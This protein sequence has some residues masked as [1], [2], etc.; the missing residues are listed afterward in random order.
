MPNLLEHTGQRV[1]IE[2]ISSEPG[3]FPH[4]V[5]WVAGVLAGVGDVTGTI[6]GFRLT[7]AFVYRRVIDGVYE[8]DT[9]PIE[10][11]IP[12]SAIVLVRYCT[13]DERESVDDANHARAAAQVEREREELAEYDSATEPPF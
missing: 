8:R 13:A 6:P 10:C 11:F 4:S 5:S 9:D 7:D 3:T 12:A 1:T 2:V